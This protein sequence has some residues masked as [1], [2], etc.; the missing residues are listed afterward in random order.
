MPV[1]L[2]ASISVNS[3]FWN[4]YLPALYVSEYSA[5]IHLDFRKCFINCPFTAFQRERRMS[6]Q[7]GDSVD[8]T[9]CLT[10]EERETFL[11]EGLPL[12]NTVPFTKVIHM[13]NAQ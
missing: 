11:A 13:R 1:P 8:G 3:G 12:P 5:N 10:E 9:C 4:I 7:S 6:T 2:F